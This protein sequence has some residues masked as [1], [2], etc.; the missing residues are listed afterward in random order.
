M[1][2]SRFFILF[3]FFIFWAEGVPEIGIFFSG[4]FLFA[5]LNCLSSVD[6]EI[7][8]S[9]IDVGGS[10]IQLQGGSF[11]SF[12]SRKIVAELEWNVFPRK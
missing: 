4:F 8:I 12:H 9:A 10:S 2:N 1:N 7:A 6:I 5:S 3:Y 11:G